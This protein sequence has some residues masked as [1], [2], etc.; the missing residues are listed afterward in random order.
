MLFI[1]LASLFQFSIRISYIVV[2]ASVVT[3]SN[4][5]L[6]IANDVSRP[7]VWDNLVPWAMH[8][9]GV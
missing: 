8:S 9:K 7:R 3:Q 6:S 2:D 1:H 4:K 5:K